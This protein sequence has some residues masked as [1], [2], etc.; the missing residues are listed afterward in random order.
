MVALGVV[1][2]RG[3]CVGNTT[4]VENNISVTAH[5]GNV[6]A[7]GGLVQEWTQEATVDIVTVVDG[8]TVE[9]RHERATTSPIVVTSTYSSTTRDTTVVSR[10]RA[11]LVP[12]TETPFPQPSPSASIHEA[13]PQPLHPNNLAQYFT[14]SKLVR[15]A[16][17]TRAINTPVDQDAGTVE[18]YTPLA[19]VA[20]IMHSIR[21]S[22]LY[23]ISN[24]FP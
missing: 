22:Y 4:I 11:S 18:S 9:E 6:R 17:I 21:R 8:V 3:V 15:E 19:P 2:P 20:Q 14:L 12:N 16:T 7:E 23:V 13:P 24:I 10:T 5:S 1:V